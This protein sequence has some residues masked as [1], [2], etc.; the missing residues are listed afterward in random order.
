MKALQTNF[1]RLTRDYGKMEAIS[2]QWG[3]KKIRIGKH[4]FIAKGTID[5]NQ[6]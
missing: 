6:H 5:E 2:V 3:K 4:L 1:D